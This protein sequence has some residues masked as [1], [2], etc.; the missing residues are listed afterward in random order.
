MIFWSSFNIK[1][2]E[3]LLFVI[4]NSKNPG[5]NKHNSGF[6]DKR[7]PP[8]FYFETVISFCALEVVLF[9]INGPIVS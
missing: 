2:M 3:D 5:V 1:K 8:Q 9:H 4:R 6:Q 7:K